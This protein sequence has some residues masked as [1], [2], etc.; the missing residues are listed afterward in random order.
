MKKSIAKNKSKRIHQCIVVLSLLFI[1][2]N[3]LEPL[4]LEFI[5]L[6]I[7]SDSKQDEQQQQTEEDTTQQVG[8]EKLI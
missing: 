4:Q 6:T 1:S 8:K 2:H 3:S 5:K 7:M